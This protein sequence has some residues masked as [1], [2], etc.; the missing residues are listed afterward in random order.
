MPTRAFTIAKLAN[1]AGVGVE[2]VRYYQKRGLLAQPA[3]AGA[4]FHEYSAS[5]VQRL[6]FIRRA[7]DLGFSLADIAELV[8]LSTEPDKLRV[9]EI[10]RRRLADIRLR[11]GQLE[12]MASAMAEMVRCCE[13]SATAA[14]PIIAAL[15]DPQD[16]ACPHCATPGRRADAAQGGASRMGAPCA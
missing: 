2:T 15:A 16:E 8:S 1:A 4:G 6:H 10:A 13:Q 7:Q 14:C 3:R 5:D 11:M 12:A 9:R